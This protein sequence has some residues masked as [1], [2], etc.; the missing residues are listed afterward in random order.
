MKDQF[1]NN[2]ERDEI[3]SETLKSVAQ[4]IEVNPTFKA[5]LEKQLMEAH[6]PANVNS[7]FSAFNRAMP[8][9][10]WIAALAVMA[11]VLNWVIRSIAP[12]PMPAANET[13]TP[14]AQET[15]TPIVVTENATPIPDSGGYDWRGTKL[16]LAQSLPESPTE[17]NVYL[18]KEDQ[19]AT[20]EEARALAQRFGLDGE[21]YQA[22]GQLPNATN[23]FFTDGKQS[24]SVNSNPYF[25]YIAD[26]AKAY[27]NTGA[28]TNPNAETIINDFLQSHGFDFPHKIEP[29][30]LYGGYVV[31]PLSPDG[32]PMRYE[33]FSSRPMRVALDENGQVLRLESNLMDYESFGAQPYGIITAEEAFQKMMDDSITG[34]KIESALSSS[35]TGIKE[36]R[37]AYPA[38]ETITIYGYAY[39][40]PALDSAQPAF[41]QI[42]GY[43]AT[44]N[45][46]G[47]DALQPNTFVE[48]TGQ[49]ITENGI[50]RF[51]IESWKPS[52]FPQDGLVGTLRRENGQVLFQTEQGEE[53]TIQPDVP[54]NLPLPF[55]NVFVLGVRKGDIYEWTL[56]DNRMS[57]GGGGGGGGG[58]G[59]YKLNLSGT[60]VPFPT[61]T[62]IPSSGEGNYTVQEGDTLTS[63]AQAHGITVDQLMQANGLNDPMIFI[64]Q[65]LVIPGAQSIQPAVG[66][67]IEGQRGLMNITIYKRPNGNQRVEYI[68]NY[69]PE[70]AP[71]SYMMLLEGENLQ[72]LQAYQNRP[73]EIWGTV[74]RYDDRY[75]MPVIKVERFEIPFPDLQFQIMRGTQKIIRLYPK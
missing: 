64:D 46:N 26:M 1:T 55:E 57:A 60:P 66:Q 10:G 70:N 17:A 71:Y 44:G 27:N 11:L 69:L 24:L 75:A 19:R 29:A 50:E 58:L 65:R 41:I 74:D 21:I 35:I 54:A 73:V 38:N 34:G 9:L 3:V 25:T 40:T 39:S 18:L 28:T 5:E 15:P 13:L 8:T 14:S 16:Y 67:R 45:T 53:L 51:N 42:D 68:L 37:Y 32:F 62:P 20:V 30:E 56:I 48:A 52:E 63:I 31:E 72:A 49:F 59:F 12:P 7:I 2:T 4:N 22:P 23:Y 61:A 36:W 47:M 33:F 6:Q 43:T